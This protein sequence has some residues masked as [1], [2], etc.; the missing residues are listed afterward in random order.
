MLLLPLLLLLLLLPLLLLPLLL[1]LLLLLLPLLYL[2]AHESVWRQAVVLQQH[3]SRRRNQW[4]A[5]CVQSRAEESH[6]IIINHHTSALDRPTH[7][8]LALLE[9]IFNVLAIVSADCE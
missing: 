8:K 3:S 5:L 7:I 1:L 4:P 2:R 9:P 6:F